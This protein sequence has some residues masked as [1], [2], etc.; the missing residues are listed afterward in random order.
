MVFIPPLLQLLVFGYA[1]TFDL[2]NVPFAVYN[3][4]SGSASRELLARFRGSQ[5]FTEVATIYSEGEISGIIN[6]QEALLVVHIGP[7]FSGNLLKG[8][9]V[10]CRSL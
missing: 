8:R 9:P 7:E 10:P 4:D 1:A 2:K 6:R 5:N 3:E